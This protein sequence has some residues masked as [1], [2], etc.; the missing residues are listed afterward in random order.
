LTHHEA[1]YKVSYS[2]DGKWIT[3]SSRPYNQRIY[4]FGPGN[5]L[6]QL[7]TEGYAM[8]PS[9]SS[10]LNLQ[11]EVLEKSVPSSA[12]TPK[13][14]PSLQQ[15]KLLSPQ[16]GSTLSPGD[17]TFSWNSVSSATKYQFIIYNSQGQVALDAI[18]IGTSSIV[19][20]GAEETITWKIRAGNNSDNWGAWSSL[21][22]L[23]VNSSATIIKDSMASKNY[24][25]IEAKEEASV[26]D[27]TIYKIGDRVQAKDYLNV[28]E[29]PSMIGKIVTVIKK[30]EIGIIKNN[31][32]IANG[33]RWWIVKWVSGPQ[34]WS[35]GEYLVKG[36]MTI[37]ITPIFT[38]SFED[39]VNG[40]NKLTSSFYQTIFSS[41]DISF[42]ENGK[43]GKAVHLN[44]LSSYVGYQGKYI[45]SN[46]GTIRFY[47]KPDLNFYKFY[48]IRQSA[49]KDYG[50]YK[51][52]F[53]GFLVDTVAYL[54]AFTGSFSAFLGFSSDISNKNTNLTFGTWDGSSWS[55]A[56][57]SNKDDLI[58]SSGTWYDFTF[59]WSK[60]EGKIKIFIDEI[61][62]AS[63]NFNTS[64]SDKEPFFIGENP[65]EY[66]G[67]S[68]WPY[69]PHSLIGTYD[70]LRVYDK[71]LDFKE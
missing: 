26:K 30:G 21:W 57:Y 54:P 33:Y 51:T 10:G 64:L 32:T 23:T 13:V 46:E 34:G 36:S 39:R 70:E 17:I 16:N 59:T 63:A 49:W 43:I 1:I 67:T 60:R 28:R 5:G 2:P 12:D 24:E 9:W 29:Q 71:A 56:K 4:L 44:S 25:A 58:F 35:A 31:Y 18:D 50:T 42:V 65:F 6:F 14:E 22:S 15:V 47:F 45:N 61:E 19:A 66:S 40:N 53:G 20:L 41:N 69:G 48:N 7:P 11:K 55:Y 8:H 62:K 37:E 3:F 27:K 68:Y 38:D 52:P